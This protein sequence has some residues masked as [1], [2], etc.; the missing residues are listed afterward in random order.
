MTRQ[1]HILSVLSLF[2]AAC[3]MHF[4]EEGK[5]DHRVHPG[6]TARLWAPPNYKYS[7]VAM[8]RE[9]CYELE[10]ALSAN[11]FGAIKDLAEADKIISTD[12]GAK[13]KVLSEAYNE[14][15]VRILEGSAEGKTGW[16][17]FEWLRP[18]QP[19]DH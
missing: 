5:F 15:E 12:A 3:G 1:V 19:G 7:F 6:E 2:I 9:N 10:K 18:L 17:P 8:R 14:R 4:N 11:D 16:V 13:V